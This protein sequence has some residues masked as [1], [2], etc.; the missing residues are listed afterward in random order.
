MFD[1]PNI[2]LE[3]LGININKYQPE[4]YNNGVVSNLLNLDLT[5]ENL[6]RLS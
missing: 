3:D 4:Y 2:T 1:K 5:Y 6:Q